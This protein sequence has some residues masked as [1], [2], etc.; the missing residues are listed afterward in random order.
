MII[1]PVFVGLCVVIHFFVASPV[2]AYKNKKWFH[3]FLILVFY[4]F[5]S[6]SVIDKIGLKKV[7]FLL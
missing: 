1:F 4:F 2:S 3:P 5:M 6:I 7:V